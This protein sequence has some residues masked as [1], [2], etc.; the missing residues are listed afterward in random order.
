MDEYIKRINKAYVRFS[1]KFNNR[2][3]PA[4]VAL[5]KQCERRGERSKSMNRYID[6][7]ELM[8]YCHNTKDGTIDCNDIA[9]FPTADVEPVRHGRWRW[10]GKAYKCSLCSKWIEPL[11]GDADMNY[12]PNCG[13]KN[14]R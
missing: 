8:N 12:C 13:A 9:R 6:A 1:K 5:A 2:L 11:Q 7:D 3:K 14:E 4:V 10:E